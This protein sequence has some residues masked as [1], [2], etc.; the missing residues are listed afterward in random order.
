[1]D[2]T[3]FL[4]Y[5]NLLP[6]ITTLVYNVVSEIENALGGAGLSGSQKFAAAEAKVNTLLQGLVA[7]AN[8]LANVT[9]TLPLLINSSVAVFNAS[10]LF[11][12]AVTPAS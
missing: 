2:L 4:T 9:K 7:D 8:V 5:V 6:Q 11:K 10:G 3:A 1:M 12:K